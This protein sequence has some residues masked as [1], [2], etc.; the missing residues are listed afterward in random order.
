MSGFLDKLLNTQSFM[1]HGMCYQWDPSVLW[2]HVASDSII[3][4]AYLS[5]PITLLY[6][7]LKRPE[8]R[9]SWAIVL[10]VGFILLCGITH[11]ISIYTAWHPIYRLEGLVKALT[12]FI[13]LMTAMA[14][15]PLVPRLLALPTQQQLEGE[16]AERKR[17]ELKLQQAVEDLEVS[18]DA[19]SNFA[20]LA[21]HD[22]HAPLRTVSSY[23]GLIKS[24]YAQHFDETGQVFLEHTVVG[25]QRMERLVRDLLTLSQVK[26]DMGDPEPTEFASVVAEAEEQ[27]S[28]VIG[29]KNAEIN[30]DE[31]PVVFG[32]PGLLS[33][34]MLNLI[35]NAIKFNERD[36]PVIS[37]SAARDGRFWA[38]S[39]TDNGIG[40]DR[41][42][43][44]KIFDVFQRLHSQ[45]EYEGSGLGLSICQKIVERHH[46]VLSVTS[47][48]GSGTCFTFTLPADELAFQQAWQRDSGS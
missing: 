22:L 28:V 6:F 8:I 39:V 16:I 17:V 9:F 44:G 34:L 31:L 27:L 19:L 40:I 20:A 11:F 45:D 25:T 7:R 38:I 2:L 33:Q 3:G 13:S 36:V 4:M 48:L 26:G 47:E 35:N 41:Q 21:A 30:V 10:F 15:I 43:L 29:E 1:P 14:I 12:A 37:V 24:R 42:N 18:N 23:V 5:I 32:Y 46:G